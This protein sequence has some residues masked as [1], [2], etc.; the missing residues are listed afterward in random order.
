MTRR[1]F[2]RAAVVAIAATIA[3]NQDDD[4][5][6]DEAPGRPGAVFVSG[7]CRYITTID[8]GYCRYIL[9]TKINQTGEG[10]PR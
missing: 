3:G 6:N 2:I 5:D 8:T 7:L 10:T 4:D 9:G 1:A